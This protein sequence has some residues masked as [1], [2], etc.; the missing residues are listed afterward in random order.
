MTNK[1]KVKRYDALQ[2]AIKQTIK[3][4]EQHKKDAEDKMDETNAEIIKGF[5]KGL[6]TGYDASISILKM[7]LDEEHK[8]WD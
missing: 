2:V 5:E 7:W 4:C 8:I 6:A 3:I 1:E